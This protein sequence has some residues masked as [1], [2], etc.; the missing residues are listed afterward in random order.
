VLF[1]SMAIRPMP[2]A[3]VHSAQQA[4]QAVRVLYRNGLARIAALRGVGAG[5]SRGVLRREGCHQK[6][7][8][9]PPLQRRFARRLD[10]RDVPSDVPW[11]QSDVSHRRRGT[12][13]QAGAA[14]KAVLFYLRQADASGH[15]P[16]VPLNGVCCRSSLPRRRFPRTRMRSS[17][18]GT[19]AMPRGEF[20]ADV[21][22]YVVGRPLGRGRPLEPAGDVLPSERATIFPRGIL[23]DAATAFV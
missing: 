10:D 17:P 15:W 18:A 6:S 20:S 11:R 7:G 2:S 5:G 12:T 19:W 1:R 21:T 14:N 3:V 22:A 16:S 4:V 23:F 13:R 9:P 8:P